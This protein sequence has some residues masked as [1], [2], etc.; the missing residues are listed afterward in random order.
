MTRR[1]AASAEGPTARVRSAA[2]SM[3]VVP[4]QR[5]IKMLEPDE[6]GA[7]RPISRQEARDRGLPVYVGSLT[8][9]D[10]VYALIGGG[11]GCVRFVVNGLA[12][13]QLMIQKSACRTERAN[14]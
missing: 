10:K 4:N 12:R 1:N 3:A 11:W 6:V 2:L 8:A 13:G 7:I 14:G 5:F 9:F